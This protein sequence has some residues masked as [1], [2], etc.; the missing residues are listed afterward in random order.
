[1]PMKVNVGLSKKVALPDDGSRGASCHVELELDGAL[2]QSDLE[3]F[4]QHVRS[5][6][7]ACSQAVNDQ[8]ASQKSRT[9]S[10]SVPANGNGNGNG[11]HAGNGHRSNRASPK[12]ISYAEQLAGQIRGL[13]AQRLDA[14]TDRMF[15]K[16]V[17][18]LSS[19]AASGLI[20]AL[21]DIKSGK[22][23]L[24]SVLN[25]AEGVRQ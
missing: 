4:H 24:Q 7:V 11:H 6:Y 15:G 2:L 14:I 20:D 1:M 16:P 21:K 10:A 8:L 22:V 5:A 18:E 17:A 25:G 9:E 23:D 12:Q 3:R 19:L 13:G